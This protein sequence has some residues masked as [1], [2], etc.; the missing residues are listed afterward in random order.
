VYK[1]WI[2][3]LTIKLYDDMKPFIYLINIAYYDII[4][5]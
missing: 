1:M 2:S 5:L 3:I 4:Y